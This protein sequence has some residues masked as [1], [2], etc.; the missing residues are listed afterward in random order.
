MGLLI[1]ADELKII[2]FNN[3]MRAQRDYCKKTF[4]ILFTIM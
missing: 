1:S 3:S 2:L 4:V